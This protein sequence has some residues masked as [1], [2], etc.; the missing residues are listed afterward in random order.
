M[1]LTRLFVSIMQAPANARTIGVQQRWPLHWIAIKTQRHK[2][3]S[4][5]DQEVS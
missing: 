3:P 4:A 1:E 2:P 5:L